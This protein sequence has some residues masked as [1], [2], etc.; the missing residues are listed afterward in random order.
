MGRSGSFVARWLLG[1]PDKGCLQTAT[2]HTLRTYL[3][4]INK[5][6][7]NWRRSLYADP[8]PEVVQDA[9]R[10]FVRF[11]Y[12][13]GMRRGEANQLRWEHV[14]GDTLTLPARFAK[15]GKP[16]TI[17]VEG[18]LADILERRKAARI[19]TTRCDITP[20]A[21]LAHLVFHRG[22]DQPIREFRRSWRTAVKSAGCPNGRFHDLRR[23][24]VRDMVRAGVPQTVAMSISGHRTVSMF[25]R[26]N[27]TD[28]RDQR[29][30][31]RVTSKY[32]QEQ[33]EK[34]VPI[35]R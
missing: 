23:S 20:G 5:E 9:L 1:L 16:R 35:A 26:Y 34:V 11:A 3:T 15:N 30:A 12:L 8:V 22:D 4:P 29:E 17:P 25:H 7:R 24:S 10:D 27:I 14:T 33:Q 2:F 21:V 31:L 32:R 6:V 28:D 19:L 18:E 13:T